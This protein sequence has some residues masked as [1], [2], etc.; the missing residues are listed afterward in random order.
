MPHLGSGTVRHVLTSYVSPGLPHP[1]GAVIAII[2]TSNQPTMNP[3]ETPP[4]QR[5]DIV[6]IGAGLSAI[7]LGARL[8]LRHP[9][10]TIHFYDRNS[11]IGGTWYVNTYPGCACDVPSALYSFAFAPNPSW[12]CMNPPQAEIKAYAD[13]VASEYGIPERATLGAEVVRCVWDESRRR[14][15]VVV[16]SVQGGEEWE[17]EC[18]I[19]FSA[20]GGLV[21]PNVPKF[22]G[23]KEFRG[24]M[25][26]SAQW[27]HGVDISG[28]KV[29]VV[30][31]GCRCFLQPQQVL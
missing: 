4:C 12:S 11:S 21:D 16:K 15:R 3:E 24:K 17:H 19:L 1:T 13:G 27:D 25:F 2:I 20:A 22:D 14:W 29:V 31:S 5:S 9:A 6:C 18:R 26:H 23:M 8:R 7:A 28:K 10:I 30:G